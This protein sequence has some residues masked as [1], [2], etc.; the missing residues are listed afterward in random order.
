MSGL[1][2]RKAHQK[3]RRILRQTM[4]RAGVTFALLVTGITPLSVNAESLYSEDSYRALSADNKAYR[5]G[6]TLTV[7]IVENSSA[8]S[9]AE[10]TDR[11]RNQ[12]RADLSL[13]RNDPVN[14]A[15]GV[16]GDFDGGG[17]TQRAG[18]LVAQLTVTVL[19]VLPGGQLL[20]GGTQEVLINDEQQR[21]SIEGKVR[22]QDIS[23]G[24]VVFS[25]RLAD[26]RIVYVG[27]GILTDR[28]RRAWWRSVLDLIGF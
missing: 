2:R 1:A 24:N 10:T 28:Q 16:S 5:P 18:R 11:R 12:L 27:E 21:I 6:D 4:L 17:R 15:T 13:S 25:N 9:N 23:D 8:S 26:A 3:A 20:L 19:D 7:V 14:V 22:P